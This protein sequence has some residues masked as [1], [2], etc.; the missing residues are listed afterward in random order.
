VSSVHRR[1]VVRIAPDGTVR[2]FV[3]EGEHGLFAALAL[4]VDGERRSL[5][6]ASEALPL[7]TGFRKEEEGRS[8]VFELDLDTGGLR[9]RVPPPVPGG[10]LSDLTVSPR[11]DLYVADPI[12]G[13]V[14]LLRK[15]KD[16]FDVLIEPGPL[17][18][19]QG[20]ALSPDGTVL[21]VADYLSGVARIDVATRSVTVLE[22]PAN[23]ALTGIDGLVLAGDSLV[24][25]QNG[26]RPHRVIRLR[27]VPGG[28][29]VEAVTVVERG[30]PEFDEP[31]LGVV[32]KGAFYFVAN[33]QY[34]A[35]SED[36]TPDE[37]KLRP[38]AILRAPLAWLEVQ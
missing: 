28:V 11:G 34:G 21:Y 30:H 7:M 14:Y 12:T 33:S 9:R 3:K 2:D 23:A 27:L 31:T 19:P 36:G 16:V 4:A 29:R 35:F 25:I 5:W 22:A 18:S 24:G 32:V 37:A 1:K 17:A 15:G 26:L 8:F 13:R 6:I 38:P 10:H 20:L